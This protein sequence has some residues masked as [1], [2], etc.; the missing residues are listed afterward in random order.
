MIEADTVECMIALPGQL[1]YSTQIPAC[2]WFL[3]RNK[4]NGRFRNRKGEVLFIDARKMGHMVSRTRKELSDEDIEK[5]AGTYHAW[6]GEGEAGVYA[7]VPGFCASADL[8]TIKGHDY[9]L[10][11]GHYV[12][13]AAIEED[14][15]PF[16]E[17][18]TTLQEALDVHFNQG[19]ILVATIRKKLAGLRYER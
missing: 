7:D 1:F 3:S 5:I 12:G 6:R 8:E 15:T 4:E 13:A 11:P 10:T 14:D 17:R 2:L 19:K 9:L 16:V 18:F